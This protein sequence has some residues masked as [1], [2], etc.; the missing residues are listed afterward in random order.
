MFKQLFRNRIYESRK[1]KYR[2]RDL[3]EFVWRNRTR[4]EPSIVRGLARSWGSQGSIELG[5]F[6][7]GGNSFELL[8]EFYQL[9]THGPPY[10]KV[11]DKVFVNSEEIE[12]ETEFGDLAFIVDYWLEN[13]LLSRKISLLQSKKEMATDKVKIELHQ[14][15][16][17][18]FW[19]DL[20]F[21]Q[22]TTLPAQRFRFQGASPD[23]FSFYHFILSEHRNPTYSSGVCSVPFIGP[24]IGTDRATIEKS[25]RDWVDKRKTEP[26]TGPPSR[27]LSL[28]LEPG[29][30]YKHGESYEWNLLP[31]PLTQF[32]LDAAYQNVG[33]DC[34]EIVKIAFARVENIIALK[35][36][37]GREGHKLRNQYKD[38]Y[39]SRHVGNDQKEK[40]EWT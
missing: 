30:I 22:G 32:I 36:A 16:L 5:S 37:G 26:K 34:S 25:L 4:S 28:P 1:L 31:K 33:T 38:I 3:D 20:E 21:T 27:I 24:A 8:A 2:I 40:V 18:Q 6:E 9:A 11:K 12:Y 39:E 10:V 13:E 15:Y 35:I 23:E 17:M 14:Q 19:P 7:Y 29:R